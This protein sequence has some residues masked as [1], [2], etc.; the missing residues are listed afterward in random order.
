MTN[1]IYRHQTGQG[2]DLVFLHGWGVNSG[3]W[4]GVNQHLQ[5]DYRVHSIDLPGFGLSHQCLP[6]EYNLQQISELVEPNIPAGA[7]LIGWSLGGLIA[8]QIALNNKVPLAGLINIA[9]S[10][11]FVSDKN[12]QGIN[13]KV[14]QLFSEQL[15]EDFAKTLERFLAI[16]AMGSQSARQD[17]KA[18]NAAVAQ[19]PSPNVNALIGGLQILANT[20]L[21][22]QLNSISVPVLNCFGRLDSLVPAKTQPAITECYTNSQTVTFDKASHAPFIS[23]PED[24]IA[25]IKDFVDKKH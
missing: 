22:Q 17:I 21:R 16:Q 14:L 19:Y 3:V 5:Q 15:Q 10:P 13:L 2:K 24:F 4:Q 6:D 25:A 1:C 11:K 20:D 23:H 8:N 7:V 9:S 12:W 18:L